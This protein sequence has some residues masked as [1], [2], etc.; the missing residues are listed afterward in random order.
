MS[1]SRVL[2]RVHHVFSVG[3]PLSGSDDSFFWS[4]SSALRT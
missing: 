3:P 4:R 1:A 2:A